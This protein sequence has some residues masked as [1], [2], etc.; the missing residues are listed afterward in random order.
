MVRAEEFAGCAA[1]RAGLAAAK[2]RRRIRL[3]VREAIRGGLSQKPG[4]AAIGTLSGS[5]LMVDGVKVVGSRDA[6]IAAPT[7]GTT[8]DAQARSAIG[9]ILG[10][11]RQHGLIEM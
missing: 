9:L 10:T 7:G 6:A 5:Q 8:V 3:V 4:R 11:M 1:V 2:G